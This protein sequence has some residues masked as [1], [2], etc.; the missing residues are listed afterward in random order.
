M[1]RRIAYDILALLAALL[2][3]IA[4]GYNGWNCPNGV[5]HSDCS[6]ITGALLIV[7]GLLVFI[8]AML[9]MVDLCTDTYSWMEIVAAA[10]VAIAAIFAI[11]GATIVSLSQP[12]L[13]FT[14]NGF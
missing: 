10:I 1:D 3:F 11:S 13:I 4:V 2:F 14:V 5:L 12:V 6:L 8:A 9:Y 7:A